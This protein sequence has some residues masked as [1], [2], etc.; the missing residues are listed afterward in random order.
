MNN[1]TGIVF[2]PVMTLHRSPY[3]THPENPNRILAIYQELLN[4]NIVND[5]VPIASRE[6]QDDELE[7][8]HDKK[9]LD[10]V[11]L[12]LNGSKYA[13]KQFCSKYNSVYANE[14]TYK[15]ARIAAGSTVEL[16]R[17]IANKTLNHGF[18]VVRPPGHHATENQA[19]GFCIYNNI[20]I[21]A[22]KALQYFDRVAIVDFDIHDG[23]GTCDIIQSKFNKNEIVFVSIHRYDNKKFFPGTGEKSDASNIFNFPQNEIGTDDKYI[24]IFTNNIVPLLEEYDPQII[25]VSAGFDAAEGDLLGGY[26]ITPNGYYQITKILKEL[27]KPMAFILEGGYNLEAV[28]KSFR[29]CVEAI[30]G[31]E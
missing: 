22:K 1:N 23:N 2:D 14:H 18:A 12:F 15:C 16:I 6:I 10:D 3:K 8:V 28:S 29:R 9:Y 31:R 20:A 21:G 26:K 5:L 13:R 11:K 7:L 24:K 30:L 19:M 25:L 27:N 4:H 17:N